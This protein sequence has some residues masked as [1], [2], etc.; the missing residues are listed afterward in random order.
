MMDVDDTRK[1]ALAPKGEVVRPQSIAHFKPRKWISNDPTPLE[2]VDPEHLEIPRLW[3][4]QQTSSSSILGLQWL[5]A[6]DT[7][8]YKFTPDEMAPTKCHIF[9]AISNTENRSNSNSRGALKPQNTSLC[10][11]S[12]FCVK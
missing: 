5:P 12:A 10:Q 9:S 1:G 4:D 8:T 11:F 6:S 3:D 7:F 2:G